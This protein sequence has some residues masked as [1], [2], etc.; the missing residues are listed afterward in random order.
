MSD[1]LQ[2]ALDAID[3]ANARDPNDEAGGPAE[4]V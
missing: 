2:C 4:L 1:R 3:A